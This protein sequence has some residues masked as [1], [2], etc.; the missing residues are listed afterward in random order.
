VKW[1]YKTTVVTAIGLTDDEK[2]HF[3]IYAELKKEGVKGWELVS[4]L[5]HSQ[6]RR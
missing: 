1:E 2:S 6:L 3:D 5:P 4:I